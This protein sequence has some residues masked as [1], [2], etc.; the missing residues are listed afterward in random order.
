MAL[1]SGVFANAHWT[2]KAVSVDSASSRRE[3][4]DYEDRMV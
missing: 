2:P 1:T 4:D 3:R